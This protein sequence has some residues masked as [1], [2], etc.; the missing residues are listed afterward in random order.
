MQG[1]F[2]R[3]MHVTV[4]D[5]NPKWKKEFEK[6]KAELMIVLYDKIISIEHVGSTSVEWLAAKPVIDID[7]VIDNNF[8]EVK[9]VLESIAYIS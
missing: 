3:T 8:K 9:I 4:Q 5:Y 1:E 7:I 2:M 6:I